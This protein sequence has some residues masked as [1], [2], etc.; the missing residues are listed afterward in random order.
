LYIL[1][2]EIVQ[3]IF[4]RGVFNVKKMIVKASAQ[5]PGKNTNEKT[6]KKNSDKYLICVGKNF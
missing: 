4:Y 1:I 6:S 5:K 2:E 3:K